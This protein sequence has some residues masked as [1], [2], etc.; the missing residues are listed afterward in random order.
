MHTLYPKLLPTLRS[1]GCVLAACALPAVALAADNPGAHNHGQAR[2]QMAVDGNQIDL[3][4]TSPAFNLA[5]FERQART[6]TEK[7]RLAEIHHWL[8]TTPLITTA[9]GNCSVVD[10]TVQLGDEPASHDGHNDQHDNHH[11]DGHSDHH[12][13]EATHRDYEVVQ[14]L[15]CAPISDSVTFDTP[16]PGRFPELEELTIEWVSPSGQGSTL[17]GPSTRPSASGFTLGE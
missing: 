9:A 14:Q 10:A 6:E 15:S 1:I 13:D 8:E 16:L 2:L 5:G 7:K 3:M 4:F 11:T 12:Y 17:I